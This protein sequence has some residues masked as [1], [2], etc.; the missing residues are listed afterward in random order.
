MRSPNLS[1][2][3]RKHLNLIIKHTPESPLFLFPSL[4]LIPLHDVNLE[5]EGIAIGF[6]F[7]RTSAQIN[8]RRASWPK[9]PALVDL[10]KANTLA[11]KMK[12]LYGHGP[13]AIAIVNTFERNRWLRELTS[14]GV[15]E[16]LYGLRIIREAAKDNG[17]KRDDPH[18]SI[19]K[20]SS[21][22]IRIEGL[23]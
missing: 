5:I 8:F 11:A 20:S 12:D 15:D 17:L 1:I 10:A 16:T 9:K 13:D 14:R 19:S 22:E 23:D 21:N 4:Y 18:A 6:C 2:G 7:L 3:K